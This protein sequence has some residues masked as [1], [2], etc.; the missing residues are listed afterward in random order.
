MKPEKFSFLTRIKSFR[1]A[2]HGLKAL[3]KE[4]HNARIHFI[5][6]IFVVAA[7]IL[8]KLHPYEWIAVIFAIGFVI[9]TEILNT[10]V[11]NLCDFISP[12]RNEKIKNI[13][14]LAAAGVLISAISAIIIGLIIFLPKI[15][16]LV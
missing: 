7:G 12:E 9:T 13:K 16:A 15:V 14:D 2:F 10:A 6:A 8:I 3:L 11:E 1:F 4:E 5:V